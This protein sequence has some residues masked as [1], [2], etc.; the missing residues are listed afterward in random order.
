M[1]RV[2]LHGRTDPDEAMQG[3]SF[4]GP[5]LFGV[6]FVHSVYSTLTVGFKSAAETEAARR[7]TGW[8]VFD[9]NVLEVRQHDELVMTVALK[10]TSR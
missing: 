2:L 1:K 8:S 4:H 3:W 6:D 7:L 9:D 5:T 10:P